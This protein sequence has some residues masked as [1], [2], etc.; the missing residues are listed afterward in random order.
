[1]RKS[2]RTKTGELRLVEVKCPGLASRTFPTP[3]QIW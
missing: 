2:S 1:M 3:T